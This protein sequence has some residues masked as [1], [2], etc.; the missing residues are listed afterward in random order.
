MLYVIS[1]GVRSGKSTYAES[2]IREN[3]VYIAT[4][5]WIDDET[6]VRIKQHQERRGTDWTNYEIY[7]DLSNS[8]D[9]FDKEILLDCLT[10]LVTNEL[11]NGVEHNEIVHKIVLAIKEISK[12]AKKLVIVT[13]NVFEEFD[14]YSSLTEDFLSVLGQVTTEICSFSDCIIECTYGI[15]TQLGG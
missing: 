11:L 7:S 1:G 5:K 13:N 2:L 4:M 8:D 3:K 10:N 12:Q 6:K 9:F 14:D 15:C